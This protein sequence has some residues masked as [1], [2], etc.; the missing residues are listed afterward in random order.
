M[1]QATYTTTGYYT[2][3]TA[4]QD[5]RTRQCDTQTGCQREATKVI[6][7]PEAR[8][9]CDEHAARYLEAYPSAAVRPLHPTIIE[10]KFSLIEERP[11][12]AEGHH[13]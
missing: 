13:A 9:M 12:L 10:G 4:Q 5:K 8:E 1:S 6:F 2:V 3:F 7:G 11:M